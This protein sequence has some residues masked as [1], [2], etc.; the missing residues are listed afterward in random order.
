V[1]ACKLGFVHRQV[2]EKPFQYSTPLGFDS[3]AL[4]V[5]VVVVVVDILC[6]ARIEAAVGNHQQDEQ[7]HQLAVHTGV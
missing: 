2:F 5:V 7:T 4:S 3:N 1:W 6:I